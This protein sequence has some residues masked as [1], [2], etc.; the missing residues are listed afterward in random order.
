VP[1]RIA[2]GRIAGTPTA[3]SSIR[4]RMGKLTATRAAQEKAAGVI[5]KQ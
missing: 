5:V 1:I 2:I 3:I 4:W